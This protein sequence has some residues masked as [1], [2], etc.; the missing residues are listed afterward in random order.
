VSS[1]IVGTVACTALNGNGTTVG[2]ISNVSSAAS[3]LMTPSAAE[4]FYPFLSQAQSSKHKCF[5][6]HVH[7]GDHPVI[8]CPGPKYL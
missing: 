6:F 1:W 5:I 8:P 7:I 3:F 4:G 2:I